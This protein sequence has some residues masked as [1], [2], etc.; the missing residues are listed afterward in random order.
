MFVSVSKQILVC[1]P[2]KN[3]KKVKQIPFHWFN[4]LFLNQKKTLAIVVPHHPSG[5]LPYIG[6]IGT[7]S[8]KG[9]V[10][11]ILVWNSVSI[12]TI[13][14]WSTVWFVYSSRI[15]YLMGDLERYIGRYIGWY[16]TEYQSIIN[17][18]QVDMSV[19][20]QPMCW[21][22]LLSVEILGGSPILDRYF[23][24]TSP[25][26]FIGRYSTDTRAIGKCSSIGRDIY[27]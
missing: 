15:M 2:L 7:C 24:D 12:L 17:R 27:R 22:I 8:T 1:N 4:R 6:Y 13:L 25:M 18:V 11:A 14:V 26:L 10:L 5:I 9:Y 16:S 19:E 3:G 21:P 20:Y 23:I